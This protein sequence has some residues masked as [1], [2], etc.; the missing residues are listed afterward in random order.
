[1][2]SIKFFKVTSLPA[3]LEPN[4]MYLVNTAGTL[5]V[6]MSDNTGGN[7]LQ[8]GGGGGGD[9]GGGA[10]PYP[11]R[12]ES[13]KL[14]GD[15]NSFVL[16]ILGLITNRLYI[17]PF[18]T[19]RPL[20]LTNLRIGV[21]NRVTG[22]IAHFGV[23]NNFKLG[24]GNDNPYQLLASCNNV[25]VGSTG[26]KTSPINIT[27]QPFIVYWFAIVSDGSPTLKSVDYKSVLPSLGRVVGTNDAVTHLYKDLAIFGLPV[28]A[29]TDLLSGTG[30][31]P[32]IYILE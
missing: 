3:V 2:S 19:P 24:N 11:T 15:F 1:M 8:I 7:A 22:K 23:Y 5:T 13:P 25:T 32:G 18:T 16:S 20:T 6:W 30:N 4:S 12:K 21:N 17:I 28:L 29:P 10:V 31:I 27:L 9:G 14:V 26:D